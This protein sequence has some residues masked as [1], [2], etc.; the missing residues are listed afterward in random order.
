[1]IS[2]LAGYVIDGFSGK[3]WGAGS[4][5]QGR[6]SC[7]ISSAAAR[8]VPAPAWAWL[9]QVTRVKL[10][11]IRDNTRPLLLLLTG[12]CAWPL[13]SACSR[14]VLFGAH[15]RI[16]CT[17]FNRSVIR[18]MWNEFICLC[19]LRLCW[20]WPTY[21]WCWCVGFFFFLFGLKNADVLWSTSGSL[22]IF[23]FL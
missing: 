18:I 8:P 11:V 7:G 17:L 21:S 5:P 2:G 22:L 9:R 1:M 3:G 15:G 13:P 23:G 16:G 20:E 6:V 10:R 14:K 4:I 12:S 19:S